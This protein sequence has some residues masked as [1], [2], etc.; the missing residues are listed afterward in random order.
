MEYVDIST[1]TSGKFS[2]EDIAKANELLKELSVGMRIKWAVDTFGDGLYA[3]TSAGADSAVMLHQIEGAGELV[4]VVHVNTGFL[5]PETIDFRDVLKRRYGFVL[6]EFGPSKELIADI[7]LL[8]LW[9][10]DME[11]Y[12]KLTRLDPLAAAVKELE[13]TAFM[14]GVRADQTENR[15]HLG[16]VGRGR[17]GEIRVHPLLDWD[18]A[19]IDQYI[20]EHTLPR[21]PLYYQGYESIGDQ[22]LTMP[23]SGRSGRTVMECGINVAD[24]KVVTNA[25]QKAGNRK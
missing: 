4:S 18:K 11:L 1:T 2:D 23:G 10:G 20:D 14:V 13:I 25:K 12:S 8:R 15:A 17:E 24:G 3:T 7:E 6:H 5:P 16:F 19:R 22:H 9:D 21:N